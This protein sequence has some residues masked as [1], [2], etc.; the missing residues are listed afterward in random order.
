ML[1]QWI[2]GKK[3]PKD[4]DLFMWNVIGSGIYAVASMV[5]TYLTIRVIGAED[6]GIFAIGLTLA[7]MFVYI[8]YYET[9]NFQVTDS[10]NKYQFEDYYAVKVFNCIIMMLAVIG[11][12]V[13]KQYDG[14]KMC[15]VILVGIYRMLDGYSDVFEG[16]FHNCGRLDLAGKS[17]AFRT[18][19]SVIVYFFI[20][21]VTHNLIFAMIGAIICGVVGIYLFNIYI[22]DGFGK[23]KIIW[24]LDKMIG[25]WREC[26]PLFVG[27][28]LWTYLLSASRIA[29]D[30]VMSGEY[31]SYY[32]V[33][34][35]PVSV[36]NLFAGFLMRPQLIPLSEL[37]AKQQNRDFWKIIRSIMLKLCVFTIFCMILAYLLGIPVLSVIVGCPLENYEMLLT[38]LVFAGGF[39][40]IACTLYYVLTIMRNQKGIMCS[41][42]I[43]SLIA[44][45]ISTPL[46]RKYELWG[47]A[48][49]YFLSILALMITFIVIIINIQRKCKNEV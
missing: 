3:E 46:T 44:L 37:W 7:Q 40:S 24:N 38:F 47:A 48:F 14:Y 16:Q 29:V 6:G 39:N 21:I 18:I 33:L 22:F 45:I 9:R 15:V 10:K 42:I 32:Q 35:M 30:N 8:A 17:M 12:V 49:S 43:S 34:F 5:L 13:V 23:I 20:L 27:M 41:Y 19:F 26:F 28:F 4:N 2:L 1:R 36:I 31:Q 11:Y 25:I